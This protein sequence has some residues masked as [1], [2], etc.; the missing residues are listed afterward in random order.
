MDDSS[1]SI[2]TQVETRL[3][4]PSIFDRWKSIVRRIDRGMLLS[5]IDQGLV[6]G[7]RFAT[8]LIV[9]RACGKAAFGHYSL[10]MSAL[11]LAICVL[12]SFVLFPYTIGWAK[13][14]AEELGGY[15]ANL[16]VMAGAWALIS[17]PMAAVYGMFQKNSAVDAS[18]GIVFLALAVVIPFCML[19]E[20]VRKLA[21]AHRN[22]GLAVL[23]DGLFAFSQ[24]A[25]L[26]ILFWNEWL[27]PQAALFINGGACFLAACA[28]FCFSRAKVK[29]EAGSFSKDLRLH[30]SVG[31]FVMVSQVL[32]AMNWY[33]VHWMLHFMKGSEVTGVYAAAMT[34]VFLSNP[35]MLAVM[36]I[37]GPR[38]AIAFH[39]SGTQALKRVINRIA[40]FAIF[41][42][43]AMGIVF[44]LAGDWLVGLFFSELDTPPVN[45]LIG[46]LSLCFV[47]WGAGG[48]F[49]TGLFVLGRNRV[50]VVSNAIR[51][52]VTTV[53]LYP[54]I[55][56]F[57]MS[58]GAIA[59]L[60][61]TMIT[62]LVQGG[63]FYRVLRL[64]PLPVGQPQETEVGEGR[65]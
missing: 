2:A 10:A 8:T 63:I 29:R 12:E 31:R 64:E 48:V 60:L 11:I 49:E 44:T 47:F 15:R 41:A 9:G 4:A 6:S 36:N 38:A 28:W 14:K 65:I 40:L 30:W 18:M 51:L 34:I 46:I 16:F 50:N 13:R 17:I 62:T 19:R 42:M 61:G 54:L 33:S 1:K 22:M 57:G 43:L 58:G 52:G 20:I 53:L 24:L 59:L 7:T 32:A 37:L 25:A 26:G 21:F 27:S 45:V 55:A 3:L 39:E 23:V 35:L 5:L 56:R